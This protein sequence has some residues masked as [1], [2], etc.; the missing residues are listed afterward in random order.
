MIELNH[1]YSMR[2]TSEFSGMHLFGGQN[3]PFHGPRSASETGAV[4][5][6]REQQIRPS[7]YM[8]NDAQ[9]VPP[10]SYYSRGHSCELMEAVRA[11]ARFGGIAGPTAS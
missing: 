8:R 7:N 3:S 2:P 1:R 9:W 10:K 5:I 11:A 6:L 4:G